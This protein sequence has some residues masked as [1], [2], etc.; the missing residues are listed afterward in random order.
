MILYTNEIVLPNIA[1]QLK[2]TDF[3]LLALRDGPEFAS[4]VVTN[5]E[6][7]THIT[8]RLAWEYYS[9]Q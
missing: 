4:A 3:Q 8:V 2:P 1:Q 9:F 7:E 6:S 5:K